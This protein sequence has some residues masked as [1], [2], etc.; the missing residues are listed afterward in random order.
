MSA[1]APQ[2]KRKGFTLVELLVVIV[3]I[4]ILAALLLPAIARAI[5]RAKV[6]SC[7]NNLRSLWQ[8]QT[9]YMSQ[10]GGRMKSMPTSTGTSFW[11]ALQT[12]Q[13]PL[14]DQSELE[15]LLCP[16]RDE[17]APG[18]IQYYGPANPVGRLQG[19]DP[20]GCDDPENH[21]P[22]GATG[23]QSEGG[24]VLRKSGDVLELSGN[25]FQNMLNLPTA[26][27]R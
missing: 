13:P 14:L 24:N 20:V 21:S 15:A 23:A 8:L 22:P 7:A 25:D 26:P 5:R 19:G 6:T 18:D 11:N 27:K 2:A 17:G 10:F 3:I 16:V 9:T 4:G 12:V 1:S